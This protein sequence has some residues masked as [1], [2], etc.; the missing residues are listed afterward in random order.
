MPGIRDQESKRP[1]GGK[2]EKAIEN[3]QGVS[4]TSAA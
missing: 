3:P 2:K 1:S 4:L